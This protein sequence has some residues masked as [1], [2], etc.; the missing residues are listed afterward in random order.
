VHRACLI[1][2]I[3]GQGRGVKCSRHS[4]RGLAISALQCCL[5]RNI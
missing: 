2:A 1:Y 5:D 3:T 4:V